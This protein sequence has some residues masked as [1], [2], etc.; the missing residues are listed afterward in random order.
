MRN[1]LRVVVRNGLRVVMRNFASF[2]G[3]MGCAYPIRDHKGV[4]LRGCALRGLPQKE[5]ATDDAAPR[6]RTARPTTGRL[7]RHGDA[8]GTSRRPADG[9]TAAPDRRRRSNGAMR[10]ARRTEPM[11]RRTRAL[12]AGLDS[13]DLPDLR[14]V[15]GVSA[16]GRDHSPETTEE[17]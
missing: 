1:R 13:F 14:R 3:A 4:P 10:S 16:D 17:N 5:S 2:T 12:P 8:A 7:E 11:G 15:R 9:T 6:R